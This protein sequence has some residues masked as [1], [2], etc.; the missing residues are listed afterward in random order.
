[1][2]RENSSF[3]SSV[4]VACNF[5]SLQEIGEALL[6]IPYWHWNRIPRDQCSRIRILPVSSYGALPIDDFLKNNLLGSV[7]NIVH[8]LH[9]SHLIQCF[10]LFG[11]TLL[12]RHLLYKVVEHF[13]CPVVHL[14]K[15]TVQL[16]TEYQTGV[17]YRSMLF[18]VAQMPSAPHS[19]R[20]VIGFIQHETGDVIVT[21]KLIPKAVVLI[22]DVFSMICVLRM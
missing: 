22:V 11:N 3:C 6:S 21:L 13:S 17:Q 19:D 1:M 20:R 7:P 14:R 8:P 9:P 15:V 18:E 4:I 16:T 10:Q 2:Y 5:S 12:C